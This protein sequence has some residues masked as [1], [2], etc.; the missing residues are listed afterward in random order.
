MFPV[1][2]SIY[3]IQARSYYLLWAFALLFFLYLSHRRA[4]GKYGLEATGT[5]SVLLW[6]YFTA[7][8][9]AFAGVA[10]EKLPLVLQGKENYAIIL[11]GGSSACMGILI[12]GLVGLWRL[13]KERIAVT[14]FADAVSIPLAL[15]LCIGRI[16]CFCEG[17]CEG[18]IVLCRWYTLHFP[19]DMPGI[20]RFPSQLA[21]AAA[22]AL[23]TAILY[24]VEKKY[25][26]K[27]NGALFALFMVLYGCYRLYFDHFRALPVQRAF[28]SGYPLSVAAV[29][30]GIIWLAMAVKKNVRK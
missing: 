27:L 13:H 28:H 19:Y 6:V 7:I 3:A 25:K 21:E 29:V 20:C 26:D 16:G 8:L 9:G 15:M 12:G 24:L 4:V 18:K 22:L 1:V 2:F 11:S 23:I 5:V 10:I 30:T 17:C 14:A